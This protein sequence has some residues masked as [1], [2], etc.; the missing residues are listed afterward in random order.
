MKDP[1]TGISS[2]DLSPEKVLRLTIEYHKIAGAITT[3]KLE[4]IR[5]GPTNV[6]DVSNDLQLNAY[7][8]I[9]NLHREMCKDCARVSEKLMQEAERV[10]AEKEREDGPSG[11]DEK[12]EDADMS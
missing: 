10:H 8:A 11:G 7:R 9:L 4:L 1:S 3:W 5:L 6:R 12:S 2:K